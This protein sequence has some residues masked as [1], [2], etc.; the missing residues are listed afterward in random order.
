M[1][2]S[3]ATAAPVLPLLAATTVPPGRS[4]PEDSAWSFI[5]YCIVLLCCIEFCCIEL[6]S[7]YSMSH[8]VQNVAH[9]A[10]LH[11]ESRVQELTLG[12]HLHTL[13]T[14]SRTFS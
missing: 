13:T 7:M 1:A 5:L 14:E 2:A 10:I 3:M 8:L 11:G 4:W 9:D 6:S 12:Q